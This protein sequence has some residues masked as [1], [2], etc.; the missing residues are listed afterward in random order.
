MS[1]QKTT[2]KSPK[3]MQWAIVGNDFDEFIQEYTKSSQQEALFKARVNLT[4]AKDPGVVKERVL[5]VSTFRLITIKKVMLSRKSVR[6]SI[7]INTLQGL[8][9]L[10]SKGDK[11]K[12]I[13]RIT[14]PDETIDVEA[15]TRSPMASSLVQSIL[16]VWKAVSYGFPV[17]MEPMISIPKE[18]LTEFEEPQPDVCDGILSTYLASCDKAGVSPQLQIVEYFMSSF[19]SDTRMF[20]LGDCI[21]YKEVNKRNVYN[22]TSPGQLLQIASALRYTDFFNEFVSIGYPINEEAIGAFADMYKRPIVTKAVFVNAGLKSGGAAALSRVIALGQH[23]LKFLNLSRNPLGDTGLQ[24]LVEALDRGK[25]VVSSLCFQSCGITAHGIGILMDMLCKPLWMKGMQAL[26]VS[27]NRLRKTGSAHLARFLKNCQLE[28]LF[29]KN[30][31]LDTE[32]IFIAVLENGLGKLQT[33]DISGNKVDRLSKE[34]LLHKILRTS[35]TLHTVS[36]RKITMHKTLLP[37]V[38]T[39]V[40]ENKHQLNLVLDISECGIGENG[41]KALLNVFQK[42]KSK[43]GKPFKTNISSLNL[44]DNGLGAKGIK[45]VVDALVDTDIRTLSL[46]RNYK[47]GFFSSGKE[48]GE[49]LEKCIKHWPQLRN[50]SFDGGDSSQLGKLAYPFLEALAQNTTLTQLSIADNRIGDVGI[51]IL[52]GLHQE[53]DI[54]FEEGPEITEDM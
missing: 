25:R 34:E 22:K 31:D 13:I 28:K 45:N 36:L 32:K 7:P 35:R 1:S 38:M 48:V 3:D 16:G 15:Q 11:N 20:D 50:F 21:G 5:L 9:I 46:D 24:T 10:T 4:T 17:G 8:A 26:D 39:A 23:N 52:S 42:L 2:S 54:Y 30:C 40:F 18:Y 14:F 6:Q 47:P 37:G 29:A 51:E 12:I 49:A 53:N 19:L 43:G 27:E 33:L 41:S 44:N